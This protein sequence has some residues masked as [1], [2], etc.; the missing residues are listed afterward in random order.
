VLHVTNGRCTN[1]NHIWLESAERYVQI[2]E[3]LNA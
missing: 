1:E 2:R 3:A